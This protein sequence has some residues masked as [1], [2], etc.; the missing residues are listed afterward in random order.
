MWIDTDRAFQEFCQQAYTQ[1]EL[2]ID[3][4]FQGE[5][6]YTP[7]LCLVQLGL[8]DRCVAVDPFRV[9]LT[10]LPRC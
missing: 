4:E 6:R 7:L 8:R 5:G 9:N 10:P 1:T 3:L 2:A